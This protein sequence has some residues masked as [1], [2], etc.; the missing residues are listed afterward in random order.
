M[1]PVRP[2]AR[3]QMYCWRCYLAE[4]GQLGRRAS[5]CARHAADIRGTVARGTCGL[6]DQPNVYFTTPHFDGYPAILVQLDHIT[7][8]DLEE[9]IVEAWLDRAPKRLAKQYLAE[10]SR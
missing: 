9:L 2:W 7:V 4:R 6:A 1:F 5:A 10:R 8:A 3:C